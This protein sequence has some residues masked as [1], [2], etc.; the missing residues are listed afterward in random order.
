MDYIDPAIAIP[1]AVLFW[2]GFVYLVLKPEFA[3][4]TKKDNA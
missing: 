1:T 3:R 4:F 2:G